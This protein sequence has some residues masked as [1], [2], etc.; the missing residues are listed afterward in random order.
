MS[1]P[2]DTMLIHVMHMRIVLLVGCLAVANDARAQLSPEAVPLN[3]LVEV[4]VVDRDVFAFDGLG[5]KTFRERLKID[6]E[7]EKGL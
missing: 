1:Y 7:V 6:E 2:A 4:L 3:D 5:V